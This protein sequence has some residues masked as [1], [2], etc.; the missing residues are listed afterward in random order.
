MNDAKQCPTCKEWRLKD[1]AC[2]Y[3][4]CNNNHQNVKCKCN[5]P[6]CW[7]CCKVKGKGPN[8]CDDKSHNSH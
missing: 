5:V 2:N 8:Q 3:V 7:K 1:N 4:T 6:W